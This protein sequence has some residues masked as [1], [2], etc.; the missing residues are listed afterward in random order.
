MK[1]ASIIVASSLIIMS[2]SSVLASPQDLSTGNSGGGVGIVQQ[3]F[4]SDLYNQAQGIA[5][6]FG[7]NLDSYVNSMTDFL[8]GEIGAALDLDSGQTNFFLSL[9][10]REVL[11]KIQ[12]KIGDVFGVF[13]YPS[14]DELN[15]EIPEIVIN[16]NHEQIGEFTVLGKT[17]AAVFASQKKITEAYLES[18]LGKSAQEQ[19][20]QQLE[21]ITSLADHSVNAAT[22][23]ASQNVTQ[24][25]L[26][27]VAIQNADQAL[28]TSAMY[29]ELTQLGL[30]QN[31]SLQELS[32]ISSNLEKKDW[33]EKVTS[34]AN[35]VGI[36]E[37]ITQFGSLF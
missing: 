34:T 20:K 22:D 32:K 36:V 19:K 26:K 13:G 23:A 15:R 31:M 27:Q 28:I 9:L 2:S 4:G 18:R 21:S 35:R 11:G 1:K 24:D 8:T 37:A 17:E 25:V 30:N 12:E 14:P 33:S 7:I 5:V 3:I 6:N 10:N 16:E 29:G